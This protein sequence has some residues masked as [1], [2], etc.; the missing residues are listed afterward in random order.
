MQSFTWETNDDVSPDCLT[1]ASIKQ[2]ATHL[3]GHHLKDVIT[4]M[5]D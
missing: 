3:G 1:M 2:Q 4:K 5:T